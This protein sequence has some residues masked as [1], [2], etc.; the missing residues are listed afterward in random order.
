MHTTTGSWRIR[1]L[2]TGSLS[3]AVLCNPEVKHRA[4]T[5][6]VLHLRVPFEHCMEPPLPLPPLQRTGGRRGKIRHVTVTQR[7]ESASPVPYAG[8]IFHSQNALRLPPLLGTM[9]RPLPRLFQVA[10]KGSLSVPCNPCRPGQTAFPIPF[11]STPQKL[12][13]CMVWSPTLAS[14]SQPFLPLHS[15]HPPALVPRCVPPG[16]GVPGFH[17]ETRVQHPDFMVKHRGG[18]RIS[19]RNRKLLGIFF[20]KLVKNNILE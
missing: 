16:F 10:T 8:K 20:S 17:M 9:F 5:G 3:L 11:C 15:C 4:V 18:P 19:R 12:A 2:M 6:A 7:S 1:L 13:M 14:P